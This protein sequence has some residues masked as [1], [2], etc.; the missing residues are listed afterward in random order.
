MNKDRD[1]I[2]N[3]IPGWKEFQEDPDL[4]RFDICNPEQ[5][6]PQLMAGVSVEELKADCPR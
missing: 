6:R 3:S 4:I 5:V 2:L 1:K